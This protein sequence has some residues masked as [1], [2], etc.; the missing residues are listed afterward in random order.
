M[1]P[2]QPTPQGRRNQ[3]LLQ[4]LYYT[5]ARVA[6]AC[7]LQWRDLQDLAGERPVVAIHGKA[8]V[9]GTW[10]CPWTVRGR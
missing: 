4:F 1:Q 5:G 3:A 10:R 9:P 6:E 8:G 7:G 2:G